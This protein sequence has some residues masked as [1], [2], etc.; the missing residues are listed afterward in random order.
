M[1]SVPLNIRR[2]ACTNTDSSF[3]ILVENLCKKWH[4]Y[5]QIYTSKIFFDSNWQDFSTSTPSFLKNHKAV[6]AVPLQH[7]LHVQFCCCW[8]I[9]NAWYANQVKIN[10]KAN[11]MKWLI[12]VWQ[13]VYHGWQPRIQIIWGATEYLC[14]T[15]GNTEDFILFSQESR[16]AH[17]WNTND[18]LTIFH[19]WDF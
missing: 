14:L 3:Q 10:S 5:V 19:Y 11:G 16:N 15:C 12:N 17:R 1:P 4:I 13:Q 18:D 8:L 7:G 9:N 2:A 6:P